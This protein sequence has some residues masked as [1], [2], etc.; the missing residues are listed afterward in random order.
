MLMGLS[1]KAQAVSMFSGGVVFRRLGIISG[2]KIG[3]Y[4]NTTATA[5]GR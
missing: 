1:G 3:S 4:T 2:S 5:W